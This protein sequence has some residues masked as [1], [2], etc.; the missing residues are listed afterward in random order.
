MVAT[1]TLKINSILE[2]IFADFSQFTFEIDEDFH[3]SSSARTIYYPPIDTSDDLAF[4]LHE[5]SHAILK[6]EDYPNDTNLLEMERQAWDYMIKNLAP[7]YGLDISIQDE[8]VQDSLDS[9][10]YWL[11]RRSTCPNCGAIGVEQAK[12]DYFCLSCQQKWST[13]EAR[14]CQ[15][16]RHKK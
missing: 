10:R 7:K 16:R 3:W 11:H 5:I 2:R 8:L 13:N 14:T 15:L 6:H 12:C 1:S 9:Y 4:L